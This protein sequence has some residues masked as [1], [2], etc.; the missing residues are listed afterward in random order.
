MSLSLGFRNYQTF[1]TLSV[2]FEEGVQ[3]L[4]SSLALTMLKYEHYEWWDHSGGSSE[5][6]VLSR[7]QIEWRD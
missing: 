2:G 5:S 7:K 6:K 1:I 3:Q 4:G